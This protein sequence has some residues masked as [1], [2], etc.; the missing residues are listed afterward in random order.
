MAKID[1]NIVVLRRVRY[2]DRHAIVTAWS[3]E[4]GRV[5]LLVADGSG[6][7]AARV[8]GLTAPPSLLGCVADMRPGRD[9][10]PVSQLRLLAPLAS[11]RVNPVKGMVAMFLAEVMAGVMTGMQPDEGVFDFIDLSLRL[12]DELPEGPAVA[13]FH[14]WFLYRLGSC[15]GVEPDVSTWRPGSLLD[16]RDGMFRPVMP[17][18]GDALDARESGFAARLWRMTPAN[19]GRWRLTRDERNRALDVELRYLSLHLAP[20]LGSLRSLEVLRSLF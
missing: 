18:H 3:R 1:L 12:L 9:I 4:R 7:E 17:V 2:S 20:A 19:M 5:S 13:N 6:R 15:L 11:V 16:M 10:H 14:V 8:R